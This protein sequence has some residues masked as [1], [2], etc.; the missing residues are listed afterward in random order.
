MKRISLFLLV[1]VLG[2]FL[3][4]NSK[5][6][7]LDRESLIKYNQVEAD[8]I[9]L[10]FSLEE[11]DEQELQSYSCMVA[12]PA[13]GN[14][15]FEITSFE[16]E[17]RNKMI[18]I[19]S[20]LPAEIVSIG[21]PVIVRDVRLVLVTF[22][23]FQY[24]AERS[25]LNIY[26][27][28]KVEISVSGRGGINSK[29]A[30]RK[31]SRAYDNIYQSTILNAAETRGM[32]DEYQRP[33]LLIIYPDYPNVAENMGYLR[34]WKEQKGFEVNMAS[35]GDIGTSNIAIKSYIQ[36]AYDNWENPPEYV[37]LVGDVNGDIVIPTWTELIDSGEGDNPY[38]LLEG[39]DLLADV[40]IGRFSVHNNLELQTMIAKAI[41]Y[42]KQPYLG[43]LD[44]YEKA[45]LF[46]YGGKSKIACCEAVGTYILQHNS[47]FE[48]TRLYNGQLEGPFN[49]AINQG[50]SYVCMRDELTMSGWNN[51]NIA[52]L[53]NG[54]MLPFATMVTCHSGSMSMES[55][56]EEFAK[57]GSSTNPKGG[58]AVIGTST[59][60]TSTC[61][62]N[63]MTGGAFY[64]IFVDN[65]Y[66]PGGAL[67]RG[68]LNIYEQY[69][70]NPGGHVDRWL[71]CNN[72]FGDPSIDLWTGV[73]Q[74][75]NVFCEE[76]F[77]YGA[78]NWQVY[79]L[80]ENGA[81][82]EGAL[83]TVRGGEYYQ[84]GFTDVSGMY[85]LDQTGMELDEEYE[86]TITCHNKIPFL[87]EFEVVEAA[88]SL[89]IEEIILN[90]S[91]N[92][93][94]ANPGE[95]I[96][97]GIAVHNYGSI[98]AQQVRLELETDS[99]L[100]ELI[101]AE[102]NL[103]DI[104]SGGAVLD[105][106]LLLEV[107]DSAL[108]G[109]T[110]SLRLKLYCDERTWTVPFSLDIMGANLSIID[111][112]VVDENSQLDPGESVE[113]YFELENLGGLSALD[114]E[115]EL[116]CRDNSLEI[117]GS[118]SIFGDIQPGE[119]AGNAD[120]CFVITAGSEIIPGTQ[121]AVR[122]HLS[123][124]SGYD[125]E[126][127]YLIEVGE[128]S[129]NDPLGPDEYG[130][131]CYDDEDSGYGS[132]PEYDW[133]DLVGVGTL[134]DLET[135]E[136]DV[137]MTDVNIPNDFKFV[138]YGEEYDLI[139]V[140][141]SGWICP[142][143]SD[144]T[145]FTNWSIPGPLGASPMIAAF[146]DDL[147]TQL[148]SGHSQIYVHYDDDEHY[149]IIEWLRMYNDNSNELETFEIIIYDAEYYPTITGDSEIKIQYQIYNNVNIG[150][151]GWSASNHGQY[152]TIGLEDPS[153]TIGLQYTYNNAYPTAAR[154]L[155]NGSVILFTT[156][157]VP[158][159]SPWLQIA[160]HSISGDDNDLLQAGEE[161]CVDLLV[162]NIGGVNATGIEAIAL[163]NDPFIAVSA[164]G[165]YCEEIIS[166]ESM[167]IEYA[168]CLV[169]SEDVPDQHSF[170]IDIWLESEQGS[171]NDELEFTAY[172]QSS[173][174]VEP[175]S[176]D[177]E[178]LWGEQLV[179]GITITNQGDLPQ[180]YY[181]EIVEMEAGERDMTGSSIN[182]DTETYYPGENAVWTFQVQKSNTDNE[183]VKDVWLNFPLGVT[184]TEAS[185]IIGGSGGDLI[186]DGIWGEGVE[187]NWHGETETG[188]GVLHDGE[189]G[190]WEVE[191]EVS[192]DFQNS[193]VIDYQ[194]GGDGYG[195][196][197]HEVSGAVELLFP[198]RWIEIEPVEG[199][200]AADESAEIVINIDTADLEEMEYN[201]E[202]IVSSDNWETITIPVRILPYQEENQGDEIPAMTILNQNYP[203]PF[204]PETYIRYELAKAG[205]V[206]L[207]VYNIKGQIVRRLVNK[208]KEAGSYEVCW[209]GR[210]E[211]DQVVSSGI[212]FYRLKTER[213]IFSRRMLLLK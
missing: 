194:I 169:I 91:G 80:D 11:I 151:Y 125:H 131:Y 128:V 127:M 108:G 88:L 209:D 186:W 22:C 21:E 174:V 191:V 4:G 66:T 132:C 93:G 101:C 7:Y 166:G 210:D 156:G 57:A 213:E 37:I 184:I 116:L 43:N 188:W 73:P 13:E 68:K 34:N 33:S 115:G 38:S 157:A 70:Q 161:V 30:N 44:W 133:V 24:D 6:E 35:T 48:L 84:T 9:N 200:L 64:G 203:N 154:P 138:F 97:L 173:F 206:T 118:Q 170:T 130:Y 153:A 39:D 79:I 164:V 105:N 183:W 74:A 102:V 155:E 36:D 120:D 189:T 69:P 47:N 49:T 89:G 176:L 204:N 207:E 208:F 81:P 187:V 167:L 182:C 110:V 5:A 119:T 178:I 159:N 121:I 28:I 197:P 100:V 180:N 150:S 71:H 139:T 94:I 2:M 1:I 158:E 171:W 8:R 99:E 72:L 193:L 162:H 85:Y 212:Y 111:F 41:N 25:V 95:E 199:R 3:W 56:A 172:K 107:D 103:G 198:L 114:I 144:V 117:S 62:N 196:E 179:T 45:I 124:D 201:C 23:P 137:D 75:M 145:S 98:D 67:L 134:L 61:F 202:L 15:T 10:E 165:G 53:N 58:I 60:T 87:E 92:D 126:Q 18:G 83:V 12:I 146:W 147:H 76:E 19:Q 27:D 123:N 32:R 90:D 51:A 52:N 26:N 54:W 59:G 16:H 190:N 104:I 65:I 20:D 168:F 109:L 112:I 46:V 78:N 122:L 160:D 31:F 152:C 86:V 143:G 148:G 17:S 55:V 181:I 50:C 29:T 113:C 63:A 14:V 42:E 205:N 136:E 82:L 140:A 77:T 129:A 141:T 177:L 106:G 192:E 185:D 211:D 142:G 163:E 135:P 175:D 40:M 149:Y 96:G 195:V